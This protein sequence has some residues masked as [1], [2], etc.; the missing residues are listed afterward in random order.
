MK[1]AVLCEKPYSLLYKKISFRAI[2]K[3]VETGF[4]TRRG[5]ER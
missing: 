3:R 4:G 5:V 2:M 1:N